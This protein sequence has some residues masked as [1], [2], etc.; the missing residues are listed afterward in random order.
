MILDLFT[1]SDGRINAV[2]RGARGAKKSSTVQPFTPI[3]IDY[4]GK[5]ELKTLSKIDAGAMQHLSGDRLL[6]GMYINELLVRLLGKYV[7]APVFKVLPAL[8]L[9]LV[10]DEQYTTELRK[11][12]IRLLDELGYGISFAFEAGTGDMVDP[13]MFYRFVADEGFHPIASE[14]KNSFSGVHLL[15]MLM[16]S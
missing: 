2:Q 12:E 16:A 13:D 3:L 4:V 6:L 15:A 5:G 11:F 10:G 9:S 8:L 1:E 7:P 14:T